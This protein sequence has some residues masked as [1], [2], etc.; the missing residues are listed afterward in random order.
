MVKTSQAFFSYMNI[1]SISKNSRFIHVYPVSKRKLFKT[2][3]TIMPTLAGVTCYILALKQ[4]TA[5]VRLHKAVST[6]KMVLLNRSTIYTEQFCLTRHISRFL[7]SLKLDHLSTCVIFAFDHVHEFP[8][9]WI[10]ESIIIFTG[11]MNESCTLTILQGC[12]VSGKSHGKTKFSL[13]WGILTIS[14]KAVN[15]QGILLWQFNFSKKW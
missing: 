7:T 14:L 10:L 8:K 1:N 9:I 4:R 13:S 5:D 6:S 11:W 3:V 2:I 15:C 12:Q